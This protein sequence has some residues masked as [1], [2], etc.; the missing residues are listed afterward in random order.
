MQVFTGDMG[1]YHR[2]RLTH[3]YEVAS[4]ARTL[5]RAMRLNEDLIEA[6]ALFHDIGHPPF[7]HAGEEALDRCLRAQGGFS[8]NRQALTIA[9]ELE[10]RY[11]RFPGLNLTH[12][13]LDGQAARAAG[14]GAPP[15]RPLEV[16]T[17]DVADSI[18]YDAHDTD[19]AVKLGLVTLGELAEI[20]LIAETIRAVRHQYTAL[21]GS[22]LRKAVVHALLDCQVS[23]VL[24]TAGPSLRAA[25]FAS[26]EQAMQSDFRLGP[27]RELAA[28]KRELEDFLYHRV[29]RHEQLVTVRAMAQEKLRTLF[30][31]LVEH[32]DWLPV[33]FQR[34]TA[35]VG[36]KRSIGDYLAGMTDRFCETQFQRLTARKA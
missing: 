18:T 10:T 24:R 6:L 2:T 16:Q 1:D 17:V 3:T 21:R 28:K 30:E 29:Y 4:I 36:R 14:Q 15:A 33:K 11:Q 7:G 13:V 34:R 35:E 23:D 31:L 12:E 20:P 9:R 26:A 25:G 8:H 32:P 22:L 27:S 19:D 5:G